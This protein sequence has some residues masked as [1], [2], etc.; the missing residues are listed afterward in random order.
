MSLA[1]TPAHDKSLVLILGAG[2]SS[3]V[4]LPTGDGLK[5]QIAGLL[6][7]RF[8]DG[9]NQNS[10]DRTITESFKALAYK[11]GAGSLDFSPFVNTAWV[12]RDAMPQATSIDNFIDS[13]RSNAQIALCGKLA[14]AKAILAAEASSSLMVDRTNIYN[15]LNFN[16]VATTWFNYF[17][18]LLVENCQKEELPERLQK[19]AII[20]FNYDRCLEHYLYL[21]LQNYYRMPEHEAAELIKLIEI[22]HPYGKVGTLPWVS[23]PRAIEYGA[24]PNPNQLIEITKSLRTFTEGTDPEVSDINAIRSTLSSASRVVFLGFAFHRLNLDL[25]FSGLKPKATDVFATGYGLSTN[26]VIQIKNELFNKAHY[27][28]DSI[29][30]QTDFKCAA[31]FHEFKRSLSVR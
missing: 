13:H 4:N 11:N 8:E 14:I 6:D 5:K 29:R 31:L 22:H 28:I 21:A 18:Q 23:V 16:A 3:E 26:D 17:F 24:T 25:L 20:S 15:K 30:I 10:G 27:P 12:I 19:I 1:N 2:A 7:I 9:I